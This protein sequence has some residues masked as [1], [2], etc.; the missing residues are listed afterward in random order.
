MKNTL[1]EKVKEVVEEKN[2]F[3]K[4]FG[5]IDSLPVVTY[6]GYGNI[7]GTFSRLPF[8]EFII[9]VPLNSGKFNKIMVTA[10][11]HYYKKNNLELLNLNDTVAVSG[12]F[13]TY[14][15]YNEEP[16]KR[17]KQT[18]FL[19]DCKK[20][21][22]LPEDNNVVFLKGILVN[23]LFEVQ[24]DEEGRPIQ[25]ENG[26]IIYKLD[27]EGNRLPT[28]RYNTK[29]EALNDCIIAIDRKNNKSSYPVCVAFNSI[30]TY[31][32]DGVEIGDE[33]EVLGRIFSREYEKNNS[34]YLVNEIR[35]FKIT[36]L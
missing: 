16:G 12:E 18:V 36:K 1:D 6:Y 32:R 24:L 4:I 8:Y 28:V 25:G 3:A 31:I 5:Y 20:I 23:K 15:M 30:A 19:T 33:V 35:L 7:K 29:K 26:K 2:N 14:N 17:L 34:K 21:E 27:D 22:K 9:R 13:R 10:S 11:Q